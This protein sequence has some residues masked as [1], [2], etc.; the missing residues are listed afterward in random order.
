ML[1][2]KA[3]TKAKS[4][5]ILAAIACKTVDSYCNFVYCIQQQFIHYAQI[6]FI[7]SLYTGRCMS[8][9]WQNFI[10]NSYQ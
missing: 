4:Q 8:M 9:K 10:T 2:L 5:A 3:K 6:F 1:T 7:S